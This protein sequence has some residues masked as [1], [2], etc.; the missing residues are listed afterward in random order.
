[1]MLRWHRDRAEERRKGVNPDYD[2]F[3]TE[4]N[5]VG[6]DAASTLFWHIC[7]APKRLS[8]VSRHQFATAGR[9]HRM[10]PKKLLYFLSPDQIPRY[11]LLNHIC[12]PAIYKSVIGGVLASVRF[13]PAGSKSAK[14]TG[15]TDTTG[16][17]CVLRV[18][19]RSDSSSRSGADHRRDQ[20]P[21]W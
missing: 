14:L 8:T 7:T 19:Q 9:R 2:G 16:G 15:P 3:N 18:D 12:A 4:M 1:M 5:T 20:I 21:G 11:Q 6:M 10:S 13:R 17:H